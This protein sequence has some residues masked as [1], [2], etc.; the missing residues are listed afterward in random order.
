MLSV[1]LGQNKKFASWFRGGPHFPIVSIVSGNDIIMMSFL[2][3]W[4]SNL[5]IFVEL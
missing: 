1:E 5:H 3:T 2:I 4:F